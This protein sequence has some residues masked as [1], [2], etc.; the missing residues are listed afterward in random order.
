MLII[1]RDSEA[2]TSPSPQGSAMSLTIPGFRYERVAVADG[3]LL[4]TAIG[5]P[6]ARPVR[7][8]RA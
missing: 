2:R 7:P 5:A 8:G 4:N 6:A 3:V 1:G